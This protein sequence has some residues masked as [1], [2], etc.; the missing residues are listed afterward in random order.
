MVLYVIQHVARVVLR[1]VP[2]TCNLY[3][4]RS[5]ITECNEVI[6]ESVFIIQEGP[7]WLNGLAGLSFNYRWLL[8]CGFDSHK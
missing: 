2:S 3:G 7:Q 8:L 1:Q 5:Q 4:G 6:I